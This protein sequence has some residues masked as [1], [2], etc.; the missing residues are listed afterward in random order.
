MTGAASSRASFRGSLTVSSE[1]QPRPLLD[2]FQRLMNRVDTTSIAWW[3]ETIEAC[4]AALIESRAA[5]L[6]NPYGAARSPEETAEL[7]RRETELSRLAER[8]AKMREENRLPS[9][10][11]LSPAALALLRSKYSEQVSSY[12]AVTAAE[13]EALLAELPRTIVSGLDAGLDRETVVL[14]Y[15]AAGRSAYY[16][17]RR[18]GPGLTVW[19]WSDLEAEAAGRVFSSIVNS[20]EPMDELTALELARRFATDL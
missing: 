18:K 19:V 17:A 5:R 15:D 10:S 3:A 13:S 6:D 16:V 11:R 9:A 7:E 2:R 8:F 4:R 1:R 20:D 14:R 12:V